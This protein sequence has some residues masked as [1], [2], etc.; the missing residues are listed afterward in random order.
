LNVPLNSNQPTVP[1]KVAEI[2]GNFMVPGKWSS[3]CRSVFSWFLW[4]LCYTTASAEAL[5]CLSVRPLRLFFRSSA[6]SHERLEQSG[7]NLHRIFTCP[8][9][10]PD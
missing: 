7:W 9:W 1:H 5:C 10:W 6:M 4:C 2:P 3:C 8:W